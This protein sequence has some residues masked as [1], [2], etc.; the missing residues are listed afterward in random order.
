MIDTEKLESIKDFQRCFY[1]LTKAC[2]KKFMGE[3]REVRIYPHDSNVTIEF[4]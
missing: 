4:A 2:E 1:E 3:I